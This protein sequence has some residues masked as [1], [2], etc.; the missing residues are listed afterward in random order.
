MIVEKND[1]KSDQYDAIIFVLRNVKSIKIPSFIKE[2]KSHS[3]SYSLIEKVEFSS[4]SKLEIIGSYAFSKSYNNNLIIPLS[5]T[6]IYEC[7]FFDCRCLTSIKFPLDS[8]LQQISENV[9]SDSKIDEI[10]IPKHVTKICKNAFSGCNNLY[11][12]DFS[13]DSELKIIEKNAIVNTRVWDLKIPS[14]VIELEDECFDQFMNIEISPYNKRYMN[15]CNQD[16]VIGKSDIKSD[17]YDSLIYSNSCSKNI[18]IPSNIRSINKSVFIE[19]KIKNVVIHSNVTQIGEKA[20]Y[21][22]LKLRHIE[23]PRDSSILE[24]KAFLFLLIWK[25]CIWIFFRTIDLG[26]WGI[27]SNT[28]FLISGIQCMLNTGFPS[29]FEPS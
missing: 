10:T 16:Y 20:F 6:N 2:I 11:S 19:S 4:D 25:T 17:I 22:C 12:I 5:V 3:F 24:Y 15:I 27:N 14:S 18:I 13:K 28:F 9:F 1:I 7:A 8:K 29:L 23:I 26:F 21:K